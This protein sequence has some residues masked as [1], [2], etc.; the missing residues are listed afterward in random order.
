[1]FCRGVLHTRL[2]VH[3]WGGMVWSQHWMWIWRIKLLLDLRV[4]FKNCLVSRI[5]QKN[6]HG[7]RENKREHK[8]VF[9]EKEWQQAVRTSHALWSYP[10]RLKQQEA[11]KAGLELRSLGGYPACRARLLAFLEGQS[12]QPGAL[13][14]SAAFG[15]CLLCLCLKPAPAWAPSSYV[16]WMRKQRV[17]LQT[18]E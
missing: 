15:I 12:R 5:T 11:F 18:E 2:V 14:Q 8:F 13:W 9:L 3:S 10:Q 16:R 7:K 4:C 17:M 1:M 6:G